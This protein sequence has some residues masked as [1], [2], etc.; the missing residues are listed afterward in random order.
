MSKNKSLSE[1]YFKV[2]DATAFM[3]AHDVP[4]YNFKIEIMQDIHDNEIECILV[5]EFR[6]LLEPKL[7]DKMKFELTIL[8]FDKESI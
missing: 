7:F 8:L 6:N 4:S 2:A 3:D 1:P 5:S